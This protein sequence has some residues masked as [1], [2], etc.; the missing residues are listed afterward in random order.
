MYASNVGNVRT[1]SSCSAAGSVGPPNTSGLASGPRRAGRRWARDRGWRAFPDRRRDDAAERDAALQ[2]AQAARARDLRPAG[3]RG[4]G[5]ASARTARP[6]RRRATSARDLRFLQQAQQVVASEI[7]DARGAARRRRGRGR[8]RA[9]ADRRRLRS[10]RADAA[11]LGRRI[12]AG[13]QLE[14]AELRLQRGR[15]ATSARAGRRRTTAAGGRRGSGP[16]HGR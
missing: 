4:C 6:R 14:D 10:A 3:G 2:P 1:A 8:S 15:A 16:T 5:R 9:T 11:S 12:L 7:V 13:A